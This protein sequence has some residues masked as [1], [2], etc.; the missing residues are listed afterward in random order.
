MLL[1]KPQRDRFW[2]EWS[3]ACEAQGWTILNGE[4]DFDI[5]ARRHELLRSCGFSSLTLVDRKAGFDKVLAA[6]GALQSKLPSAHEQI[7]PSIGEA[8]RTR[9]IITAEIL[10]CLSLYLSDPIPANPST[11]LDRARHYATALIE[12][13][14]MR[15]GCE[16]EQFQN[17][18]FP[19][20]LEFLDATQLAHLRSTL[21]NRLQA[22]RKASGDTIHDM[23]AKSRTRCPCA[24]CKGRLPAPVPA[25]APAETDL[26]P[27]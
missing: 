5:T 24:K 25:L 17:F 18:T 23:H 16:Q 11:P 9:H 3:A 21:T 27:F 10:P 26:N 14:L 2:R 8:R 15:G 19:E 1:S 7:D 4:T 6:L 22:K 13:M 12:E 20:L